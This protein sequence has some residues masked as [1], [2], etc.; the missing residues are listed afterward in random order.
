M[1]DGGQSTENPTTEEGTSQGGTTKLL[2][3]RI[4]AGHSLAKKDI[5]GAS[6][7][8]VRI[9]LVKARGDSYT[10]LD[11]LYTKTKKK[12]LHPKWDEEFVI[13][14]DPQE[15]KIVMEVFDENRL[16]RDDFLGLVELPLAAIPVER[17][18]RH[19]PHKYYLLRPRSAKSR[20]KGHL[21]VYHAYL[22]DGEQQAAENAN[23]SSTDEG[24]EVVDAEDGGPPSSQGAG[25]SSSPEFSGSEAPPSPLPPGWEEREDACGRIYYVNHVARTTQWERPIRGSDGTE[26]GAA[27]HQRNLDLAQEFQRRVHISVD[28]TADHSTTPNHTEEPQVGFSAPF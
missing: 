1:A 28:E 27:A 26:E 21:Q 18:G 19:I 10:V 5:F 13:K 16:T 11:S 8:Y 24:W 4:V 3:L 2:R 12:T 14:V 20:V 15:H 23:Q 6:D 25:S 7:P 17:P 9:D 22:P